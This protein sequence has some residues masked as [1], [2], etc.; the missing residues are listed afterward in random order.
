M[1]VQAKNNNS[2]NCCSI[3][4]FSLYCRKPIDH[5]MDQSSPTQR[6]THLLAILG[7]FLIVLGI[8][9][10]IASS[11][12]SFTPLGRIVTVLIPQ[13]V[14]Y[15][16]V[17]INRKD[18]STRAIGKYALITASVI[19]PFVLGAVIYQSGAY[20]AVDAALV[21]ILALVSTANSLLIE[22]LGR[23]KL[24]TPLTLVSLV[25]TG[26]AFSNWMGL[27]FSGFAL[28]MLLVGSFMLA[29]GALQDI[30][31]DEYNAMAW[32]AAGFVIF[33]GSL[34]VLPSSLVP[35][36]V[37]GDLRVTLISL[38]YVVSS[39]IL[40]CIT[41]LY[42][43]LWQAQKETSIFHEIRTIGENVA[44]LALVVP[45]IFSSIGSSSAGAFL[46]LLGASLISI[47][48]STKV[49]VNF[50]RR[51]GIAGIAVALVR[52]V[53]LGVQQLAAFWPILLIA[54]GL[55]LLIMATVGA[56]RGKDWSQPLFAMPAT[57]WEH[58]GEPRVEAPKHTNANTH[59][60]GWLWLIL[61]LF[62]LFVLGAL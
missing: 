10:L 18:Q 9:T 43:R 7:G 2:K 17:A 20:G 34:L 15:V 35:G 8:L 5:P 61:I 55:I 4:Y 44:A 13:V 22:F 38:G 1:A 60:S 40:L 45:A 51:L 31:K 47:A 30:R 59:I 36:T 24:H 56:R 3:L 26:V 12:S 58:L 21:S 53:L 33:L 48:I 11:W 27:D 28:V 23:D 25:T 41:V 19:L 49:R 6:N 29:F 42:S 14:L 37:D 32:H 46:V 54:G 62:L 50:Y 52:L 16:L 57:S 39:L